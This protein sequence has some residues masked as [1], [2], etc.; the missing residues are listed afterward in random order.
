MRTPS[1]GKRARGGGY[2]RYLL[3]IKLVL[4]SVIDSVYCIPMCV[5]QDSQKN[6]VKPVPAYFV[7]IGNC[8]YCHGYITGVY[9]RNISEAPS[10]SPGVK[11]IAFGQSMVSLSC[12][13][14]RMVPAN[15]VIHASLVTRSV[16]GA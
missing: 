2:P 7:Y 8:V 4:V 11:L 6:K 12:S 3:K 9:N 5:V 10:K 1:Q 14:E 16:L 15:T 13:H